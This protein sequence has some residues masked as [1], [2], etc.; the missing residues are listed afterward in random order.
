MNN[1]NSSS[2]IQTIRDTR[3]NKLVETDKFANISKIKPLNFFNHLQVFLSIKEL[4][5]SRL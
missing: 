4:S 5:T 2:G 1:D 3:D